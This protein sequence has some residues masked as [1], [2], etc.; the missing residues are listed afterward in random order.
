MDLS[1]VHIQARLPREG[2]R[3]SQASARQTRPTT[4]GEPVP[5]TARPQL[6]A[7][8]TTFLL[9]R[10]EPRLRKQIEKD[11]KKRK[12]PMIEVIRSVLCEHYDLDCAPISGAIR[13]DRWNDTATL[14]LKIQPELFTAIKN[15][16]EETG[17]TMRDLILAALEAH[18]TRNGKEPA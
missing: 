18:Y 7:P 9:R 16:S 5:A 4:G 3:G 15:D 14:L 12:E 1:G 11:A 6:S 17:E 10:M 13:I 2:G 8:V